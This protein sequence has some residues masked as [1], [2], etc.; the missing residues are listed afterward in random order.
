MKQVIFN[1]NIA[2]TDNVRSFKYKAK[3]LGNTVA[4]PNPNEAIK[5]FKNSA[6]AVLLK[7]LSNFWRSLE[8]PLINC[9]VE[10]RL[11]W[12]KYFVL[13]AAANYNDNN[14]AHDLIFTI[15]DT[16]LYVPVVTLSKR[17]NKRSSKT[18]QQRI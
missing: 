5:I 3:L 14:N 13:S 8:I 15:K 9:K 16:K 17:D 12:T 1:N 11:Q 7:Y 4:Q 10:L 6:T 18:S 2:N